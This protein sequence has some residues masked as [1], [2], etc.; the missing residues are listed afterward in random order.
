MKNIKLKLILIF[1][2]LSVLIALFPIP[3]LANSVNLDIEIQPKKTHK[4]EEITISLIFASNSDAIGTLTA[5]LAY[6]KDLLEYKS[7]GSNTAQLSDG[8]GR[9]SNSSSYN[10]K[11]ISYSF[12]FLA[13]KVGTASFTISNTEITSLDTGKLLGNPSKTISISINEEKKEEAE[14]P[15]IEIPDP[16]DDP[17]EVE[18][19]GKLFYI[20]REFP[21]TLLPEG[22]ETTTITIHG[23]DIIGA[24]NPLTQMTLLYVY[25]EDF[26][27]EWYVC[28]SYSYDLLY[29]YISIVAGQQFSLIPLDIQPVGF[30]QEIIEING[31]SISVLKSDEFKSFSLVQAINSKGEKG[32]YFYDEQESTM[33][34]VLLKNNT[35]ELSNSKQDN[36]GVLWTII[37]LACA[38]IILLILV[39]ILF[40]SIKKSRSHT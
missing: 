15:S 34:K 14:D 19:D 21:E 8:I 30:Q 10:T 32:Y 33:Q 1:S 18:L 36:K 13:K 25:N 22:F 11:N 5:D 3:A 7:G 35:I 17:I 37:I 6:D 23:E 29:P 9:I 4:G 26:Q 20:V 12:T 27:L 31:N 39:I 40:S 16:K 38:C 28:D 2:I 24:K